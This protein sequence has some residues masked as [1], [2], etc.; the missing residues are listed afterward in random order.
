M[1]GKVDAAILL[2][3]DSALGKMNFLRR[4]P[5]NVLLMSTSSYLR[6]LQRRGLLQDAETILQCAA[7]RRGVELA[8]ED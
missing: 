1:L 6:G 4:L 2:F 8:S 3:E 7:A 5:D